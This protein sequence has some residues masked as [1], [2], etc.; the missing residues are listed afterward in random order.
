[1]LGTGK[2][3]RVKRGIG[4]MSG[5]SV[6]GVDVALVAFRGAR[7]KPRIVLEAYGEYPIPKTLRERI[8]QC[9]DPESSS[10]DLVCQLNV[11]LGEFFAR[12][13]KRFLKEHAV[14]CEAVDFIG[15]HGQTVYHIPRVDK[16]RGW[17]TRSTLQLGEPSV[18]VEQTGIATVADFRPR[19]M[20][21]GGQG[22]PLSAVLDDWLYRK[23][24]ENRALQNI[25]GIANVTFLPENDDPVMA[26]DTGPGNMAIDAVVSRLTDG[27]NH[28]DEDGRIAEQGSVCESW[29]QEL[30]QH[31]YFRKEPPKTTGREDFGSAYVA[32]LLKEAR[33]RNLSTEDCVATITALTADSIVQAYID[34]LPQSAVLHRL[35]LSGGGAKNPVL[36]SRLRSRM[37]SV[38]VARA[39][40]C[41]VPGDAKEAVAFALLGYCA[42]HGI[43]NNI[44]GVTGAKRSVVMGKIVRGERITRALL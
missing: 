30:L 13:V 11:E 36:V 32:G 20:A 38:T 29:L 27:K 7:L 4:L 6:D 22:A 39:E 2:T 9:F 26:F 8:L 43:P 5:T 31:P 18:I 14:E 35:V 40:S 16:T 23:P 33:K 15:S 10:V 19:D 28:Y 34:H 17:T 37:P 41:G 1:M 21:A 24:E 25:G 3:I 42:L 44:P 12:C